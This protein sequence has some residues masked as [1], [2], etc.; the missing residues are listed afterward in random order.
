MPRSK[1]R[2]LSF[3]KCPACGSKDLQVTYKEYRTYRVE[4][5]YGELEDGEIFGEGTDSPDGDK[6]NLEQ[7]EA[8]SISCPKCENGLMR[9]WD[10]EREFLHVCLLTKAAK[11]KGK[12]K[13]AKGKK[14]S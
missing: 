8:V 6:G 13:N 3:N 10:S 4:R 9:I 2:S 12:A 14:E 11:K 5:V 7:C 1:N